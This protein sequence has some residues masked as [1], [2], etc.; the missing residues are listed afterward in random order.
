[1]AEAVNF[2]FFQFIKWLFSDSSFFKAQKLVSHKNLSH[3][4]FQ[5][6]PHSGGDIKEEKDSRK[7]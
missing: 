4:N 6:F 1:M 5:E 7:W 2:S 3:K